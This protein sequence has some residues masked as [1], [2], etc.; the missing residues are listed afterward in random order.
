MAFTAY[1]GVAET[2]SRLGSD[3]EVP[4][5]VSDWATGDREVVCVAYNPGLPLNH[6]I[7]GTRQ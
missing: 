6:S 1:D 3:I 5:T 4:T 2:A 7:K